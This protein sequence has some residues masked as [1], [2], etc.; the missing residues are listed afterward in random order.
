MNY[1]DRLED[2]QL[3]SLDNLRE[4]IRIF[5]SSSSSLKPPER[6]FIDEYGNTRDSKWRK[7]IDTDN[8]T[9]SPL[10]PRT[11]DIEFK[12]MDKNDEDRARP[13][14][15]SLLRTRARNHA[16]QEETGVILRRVIILQD[17]NKTAAGE[18]VKEG[19]SENQTVECY[20]LSDWQRL[21]NFLHDDDLDEIEQTIPFLRICVELFFHRR[22]CQI[23]YVLFVWNFLVYVVTQN[24]FKHAIPVLLANSY[25]VS[26][27]FMLAVY[28]CACIMFRGRFP[29]FFERNSDP[30][31]TDSFGNQRNFQT[32]NNA[33]IV[34]DEVQQSRIGKEHHVH[35]TSAVRQ[36]FCKSYEEIRMLSND[37][38]QKRMRSANHLEKGMFY[39]KWLNMALKFL[40]RHNGVDPN[41]I[42]FNRPAYRAMML[43]C[44]FIFPIYVFAANYVAVYII[45][46]EPTCR[47]DMHAK[48]C[49]YFIA[50]VI[51]TGGTL[52]LFLMQYIYGASI[53]ICLVGLAYG[54]EVAFRL[55]DCWLRKYGCLRRV[56][57]LDACRLD[58]S[59]D[60][61][62]E[63]APER[64]ST[65][66]ES[67]DSDNDDAVGGEGK[68]KQKKST[69]SEEIANLIRR[70]A[71]EHYLFI[72]CMME[73]AG[74]IWSPVLTGL[75][76]LALYLSVDSTVYLA[77]YEIALVTVVRVALFITIRVLFLIIYPVVSIAFANSYIIKLA[78]AFKFCA[79]EDFPVLGGR[80]HWLEIFERF[81][82]TWTYHGVNISTERLIGLSWTTFLAFASVVASVLFG[83]NIDVRR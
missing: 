54:G 51:L 31:L 18:D 76:V 36:M 48:G 23:M 83:G 33:N 58:H 9:A 8:S 15:S 5:G 20:F 38:K 57:K 77:Y 3:V 22:T 75:L 14:G 12:R 50:Q 72:R 82:A 41:K 27:I 30:F 65:A 62:D 28:I 55:A 13:N 35:W 68:E 81:P 39:Y 11:D 74:E 56:R 64:F 21:W 4:W 79:E 73:N 10:Q 63:P 53:L 34:L 47:N 66:N 26:L 7:I 71:I 78:E 2:V 43:F 70:D 60:R 61:W 52:T 6:V 24:Y 16:L 17:E 40:R 67:A 19:E 46:V 69:G 42:T 59:E 45:Y 44:V 32:S 1:L 29:R 49:E 37:M 80:N 25:Y